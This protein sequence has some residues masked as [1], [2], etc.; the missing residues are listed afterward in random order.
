MTVCNRLVLYTKYSNWQLEVLE[1]G[2]YLKRERVNRPIDGQFTLFVEDHQICAVV[3]LLSKV[4]DG[5]GPS[6]WG[7]RAFFSPLI[8][9][10]KTQLAADSFIQMLSQ[11][12][13][14]NEFMV[15]SFPI[16]VRLRF[17]GYFP[18]IC[19][20]RIN[21]PLLVITRTQCAVH[22][23]SESETAIPTMEGK[24]LPAQVTGLSP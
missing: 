23:L 3:L 12:Y 17:A 4:V 7:K 16:R 6:K 20:A 10:H 15:H 18:E 5:N 21:V 9:S 2:V 11:R 8:G 22:L 19:I 14:A 13:L 1:S 24:Q